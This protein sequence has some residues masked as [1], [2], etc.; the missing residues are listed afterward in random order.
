MISGLTNS[1]ATP[2]LEKLM[3][4]SARR[5]EVLANNIANLSTPGFRPEDVSVA[6]F[7]QQ[8]GEAIDH[9]RLSPT[10]RGGELRMKDTSE[11]QVR[12]GR[13][14]LAPQPTGEN[15]LFHDGNDRNLERTMQD[16]VENFM[17]FRTAAQFMRREFDS[18]RTVIR[19]RM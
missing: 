9:Q 1:G 18:L 4:F 5:H 11:V 10:A 19:E 6:G 2:T 14:T 12:N 3:Q 15:L 7:Q 8:L 13:L 17:A 16:M